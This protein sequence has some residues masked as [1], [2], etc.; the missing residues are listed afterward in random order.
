MEFRRAFYGQGQPHCDPKHVTGHCKLLLLTLP[1]TPFYRR[2]QADRTHDAVDSCIWDMYRATTFSTVSTIA[3]RAP[4]ASI[5]QDSC[6]IVCELSCLRLH[7]QGGSLVGQ[8][9]GEKAMGPWHGKVTYLNTEN[10]VMH[11][12]LHRLGKKGGRHLC[13]RLNLQIYRIPHSTH[14][15]GCYPEGLWYKVDCEPVFAHLPYCQA[16]AIHRNEALWKYVLH[17]LLRHLPQHIS[18]SIRLLQD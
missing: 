4:K 3:C 14:S 18:S 12:I 8:P 2:K 15:Q 5:V 7:M 17:E 13:L 16:D 10:T 1:F 9:R 11:A 6:V